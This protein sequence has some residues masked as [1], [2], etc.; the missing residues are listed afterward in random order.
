MA[1]SPPERDRRAA[2][3]ARLLPRSP[4]GG[5]LSVPA[6]RCARAVR[7]NATRAKA[8]RLDSLRAREPRRALATNPEASADEDRS[9]ADLRGHNR[10]LSPRVAGSGRSGVAAD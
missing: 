7:T 6:G 5:Q 4:M 3:F 9:A 10:V 1:R 8:C 2:R